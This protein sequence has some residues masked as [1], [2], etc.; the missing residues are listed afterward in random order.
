MKRK[1]KTF[2][3]FAP[4]PAFVGRERLRRRRA[5]G[6]AGGRRAEKE[7]EGK[8][9]RAAVTVTVTGEGVTALKNFF[10]SP[11]HPLPTF[12]TSLLLLPLTLCA[13]ALRALACAR[14]LPF[15]RTHAH[16]ASHMLRAGNP[17]LHLGGGG[18]LSPPLTLPFPA[19]QTRHGRRHLLPPFSCPMPI[20][21]LISSHLP[22]VFH[23]WEGW[24]LTHLEVALYIC[25]C[26]CG[27]ILFIL[28]GR[29]RK[30]KE[31]GSGEAT[32][33]AFPSMP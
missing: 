6:R 30:R 33:F 23:L 21:H 16:P 31:M 14:L 32:C 3:I 4:L 22:L 25:A 11:H 15:T 12:P 29:R 1:R 2:C 8:R 13:A 20:T 10:P 18:F 9:R 27:D 24:A 19:R 28:V 7:T 26:V 17:P 5:G